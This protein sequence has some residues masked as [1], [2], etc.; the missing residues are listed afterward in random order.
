M[1]TVQ[2]FF[3]LMA[4][5]YDHSAIVRGWEKHKDV[6][7]DEFM[8]LASVDSRRKDGATYTPIGMVEEMVDQ[9]AK[10]LTPD[11][12]VDCGCGS[13]R[14]SVIAAQ[15]FPSATV[16]A[17]DK[18]KDACEMCAANANALGL[19]DRIKV[20][21]GDFMDFHVPS[22]RGRVLWIGNPPYVRHHDISPE[23]KIR[24]KQV[25]RSLGLRA[26]GLA[27]LHVHF[28]AHIAS[29][30]RKGDF[31]ILVTSSEWM[32]VNYGS[33]VRDLLTGPLSVG[34]IHLYDKAERVFPNAETTAVVFTMTDSDASS[35]GRKVAVELPNGESK[36]VS[37]ESLRVSQRW[38]AALAGQT[39]NT[40]EHSEMVRLGSIARV[41]RG[42]VTGDNRFWVR[43]VD[44]LSDIP[45]E[46]TQ[47]I[48]SHA[49][50]I[51]DDCVAVND[52]AKLKRLIVLPEDLQS[53]SPSTE[54]VA[55]RILAEGEKRGV[56]K[57]YVASS[58]RVWWSVKPPQAPAIL[59]T[60][61][62]RRAPVFVLNEKR[63]PMLNV[64]HGI[65]PQQHMSRRAL[66]NLVAYLN[67]E[68]DKEQ[69]RTYC[70]GLV[71]FEPREAE[72]ILVP[73]LEKLEGMQ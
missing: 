28:I 1:T 60:Y 4:E 15:R 37:L 30:W 2:S 27:G 73:T 20:I 33:F 10:V 44:A 49:K 8:L 21:H 51:M 66:S 47:P 25:A 29:Q 6:L 32:D 24:F 11:V 5:E 52:T 48:V 71:K 50:E 65:Y 68:V 72:A 39:E 38:S 34:S 31:A 56:D 57:G 59:M 54:R 7:G 40:E 9:S 19:S 36:A 46:L 12:V 70:G 23:D 35:V 69:G 63:V 45:S 17:I 18:S 26:S 14:F 16:Y 62:T 41:H 58:R 64:V 61:M 13:G 67:K 3:P 53:L 22:P 43:D 42:V 55:R